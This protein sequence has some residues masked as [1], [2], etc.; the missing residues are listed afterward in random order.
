MNSIQLR[1]V[2]VGTLLGLLFV[3]FAL[4]IG[5]NELVGRLGGRTGSK[6]S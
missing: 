2:V 3:L 6:R 5:A 1:T 4:A